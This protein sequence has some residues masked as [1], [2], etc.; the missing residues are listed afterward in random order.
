MNNT[1]RGKTIST[2]TWVQG[3]YI[4]WDNRHFI[5]CPDSLPNTWLHY[6]VHPESVGR[7]I[8]I[9]DANGN[10]IFENDYVREIGE[11]ENALILWDN[12]DARFVIAWWSIIS[13]FGC[14][15]GNKLEVIGNSY[16]DPEL[17]NGSVIDD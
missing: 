9:A 10:M 14:F 13:D 2:D 15:D 6:E 8:G 7:S 12:D 17:M 5:V 1:F 11:T 16:D 4:T 3:G